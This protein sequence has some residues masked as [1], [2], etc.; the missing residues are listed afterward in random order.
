MS[1]LKINFV[2]NNI[3]RYKM[4]NIKV[5]YNKFPYS[6]SLFGFHTIGQIGLLHKNLTVN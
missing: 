6:I 2:T 5:S 4:I 1:Y 3:L